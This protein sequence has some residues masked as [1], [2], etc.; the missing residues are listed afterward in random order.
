VTTVR[1]H[2]AIRVA[3]VNHRTGRQDIDALLD[4]VLNLGARR[5]NLF[6]TESA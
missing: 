6:T 5:L 3:I 1:G 2:L 4:A